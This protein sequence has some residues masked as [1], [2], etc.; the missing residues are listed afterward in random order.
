MQFLDKATV[1]VGNFPTIGNA[2][3]PSAAPPLSQFATP[4]SKINA[5]NTP[6]GGTVPFIN[7]F[8]L[9]VIGDI[10]MHKGK[11]FISL[12]SLV[13]ALQ[14]DADTTIVMNPKIITQDNRQSNIFVGQNVPFTGAI[15]TNTSNNT[16]QT[17]N[18]EYRDIGVNLTITPI[19]GDNDV[20]TLDIVHDI[21]EMINAASNTNLSQ[22]TGIQTSHTHMDTRV[23]VPNN[24]FVVLSGMIQNNKGRLKTGLPCLGGLPVIGVLFSENNRNLAKSNVIIFVRPQ[25]I[26]SYDE[27]KKVTEH[28]EWLYKDNASLPI[29]QEEFDEGLD[30][31]KLPEN[32]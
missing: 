5:T 12:G 32:E 21:T 20:V 15:V 27:Y 14:S 22:L 6:K 26:N 24:H 7:G 25:I 29:L 4:F 1:G 31:V 3:V 13:N 19:L 9:G 16:V 17:S 2:L 8:D 30:L 11:S 28:Q 10:I 18:I 23:H